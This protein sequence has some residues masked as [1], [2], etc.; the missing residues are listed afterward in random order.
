MNIFTALRVFV[1][2]LTVA[3]VHA[4]VSLRGTP[5]SQERENVEADRAGLLRIVNDA[6]LETL[7]RSGELVSVPQALGVAPDSRLLEKWAWVRPWVADFLLDLGRDFHE[8]HSNTFLVSSAVRTDEYQG[9]LRLINKNAA[10]TFG[11]RRSTHPTG[12]TIDITK[13]YLTDVEIKWMRV[14]LLTMEAR[15]LIEV[16][17]EFFQSVFHVMVFPPSREVK[18]SPQENTGMNNEKGE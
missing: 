5:S 3:T 9:F 16:T 4:E 18:V 11:N 13:R 6:M 15:G 14:Q 8:A 10:M 1:L 12:A 7:K 2:S 17:E